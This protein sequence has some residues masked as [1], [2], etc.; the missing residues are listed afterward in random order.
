MV[1]KLTDMAPFMRTHHGLA[2]PPDSSVQR[3]T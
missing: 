2:C 3:K 1:E